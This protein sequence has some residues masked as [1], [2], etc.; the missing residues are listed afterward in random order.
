MDEMEKDVSRTSRH[1]AGDRRKK[2]LQKLFDRVFLLV[3]IPLFVGLTAFMWLLPRSAT[4]ETERRDLKEFPAFTLGSYFSGDFTA[5]V[6]EWF[7]DTVPF[8]DQLNGA[9]M[10]V[11]DHYGFR[12]DDV[13]LH[14]V[15]PLNPVESVTPAPAPSAPAVSGQATPAPSATPEP[16]PTPHVNTTI[17]DAGVQVEDVAADDLNITNNGIAV[18]GKGAQTRALMLFGG[19]MDSAANYAQ[20][21]SRY[22]AELGEDVKVYDMVIPTSSEFYSPPSLSGYND[23]QLKFINHIIENLSDDVYSVDI[24]TP[25]SQHLN[26]NIYLRTDHHWASLGA[27]YAAQ[28]FARVAEVP[29][30]DLSEYEKKTV[31]GYV[32]SMYGYSKDAEIKNN[33]EDFD[34]YVTD[35]E[36]TTVYQDF[37]DKNSGPGAPYEGNFFYKYKDGSGLAY[38]TFMGGDSKITQVT[39]P[40]K[41]GRKLVIL[42]DSFGNALPQFLFGSFEEIHVIDFRYFTDNIKDYCAE[43]GITDVLFADNIFN[44]TTSSLTKHLNAFLDQ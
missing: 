8:R 10:S 29:F 20:M 11:K 38:C 6:S 34:Y 27:Y 1:E 43:Y 13:K 42:K 21:V 33:P 3:M 32:G 19:S 28:E 44:S 35:L 23:G 15:A 18:V 9:S 17:D 2:T 39:T 4:S 40:T 31:H 37:A 12:A 30:L 5:G 16:T 41:N 25:L 14:N 7:S 24:Y 26:E 36:I 22:K